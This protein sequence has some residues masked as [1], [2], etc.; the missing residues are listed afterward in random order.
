MESKFGNVKVGNIEQVAANTSNGNFTTGSIGRGT[1]QSKFGNVK[2]RH[3]GQ[4]TVDVSN[5]NFTCDDTETLKLKS[6]FGTVQIGD[7]GN[8]SA[9][10]S[11]G[12][13]TAGKIEK[14]A[15][16]SRF[17]ELTLGAIS[18]S[19]IID[20]AAN[21]DITVRRIAAGARKIDIQSQFAA[22]KLHFDS[23]A[24]LD[25]D[26][27]TTFGTIKW[28][29]FTRYDTHQET[30]TSRTRQSGKTGTAATQNPTLVRVAAKNG[31]LTLRN[32]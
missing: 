29:G 19:L 31:D 1:I 25:Y 3:A 9:D 5:G 7:T 12:K 15:I 30:H 20:K 26:L 32:N 23:A 2:I 11:N 28:D 8:L 16:S 6:R 18:Q 17:A 24:V 21:G 22:V 14:A 10:L 27:E 13:L 4:L